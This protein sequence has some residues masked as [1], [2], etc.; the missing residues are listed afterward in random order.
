MILFNFLFLKQN[1]NVITSIEDIINN[2]Y[3]ILKYHNNYQLN[4]VKKIV[5]KYII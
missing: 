4:R 3:K 1:N 5:E 2:Y